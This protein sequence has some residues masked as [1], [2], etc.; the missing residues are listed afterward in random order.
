M[1]RRDLLAT[2]AAL[3]SG[4]LAAP[5]LAQGGWPNQPIRLVVPFS[6]GGPTDIPARLFAEQMAPSLPQRVIVENRTGAGVL[7]GTEVVAKANDGHTFLYTTVAHAALRALF[8]RLPFDP[9]GDF[10][11]VALVGVIP[12]VVTV[13]KDFAARDLAGLQAALK[14]DPGGLS[15]ASSGNGGALHLATELLLRA[16]DGRALHVP[17]RGTA[18]A[19]PDVLNGTIPLIVDV[20]TS[21]L[22]Y[23]QRGETRALAIMGNQRLPQL[24]A[25]PTTAE[26]GYPGLE[27]YTWHMVLAPKGTPQPVI[28]TMNQALMRAAALPAVQSRLSDLAMRLVTDSTPESAT[29]W[30]A[31]ETQKWTAVIREANITVN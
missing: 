14:A 15:Y 18:A 1:N 2:G 22:P 20:A 21:A 16:L 4:G 25:V 28:Q 24:P 23:A 19:M 17:Y 29:A 3:L 12:L 27:A 13:G 10:M 11:P 9:I 26:A 31:A 5:A 30:L 7:V 6:A 8:Q